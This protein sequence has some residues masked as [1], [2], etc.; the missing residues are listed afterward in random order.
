V[1][2]PKLARVKLKFPADEELV[3]LPATVRWRIISPCDP[4]GLSCP[5]PPL[6]G[7]AKNAFTA[8]VCRIRLLRVWYLGLQSA[9]AIFTAVP[10][11]SARI[12]CFNAAAGKAFKPRECEG[13]SGGKA[14]GASARRRAGVGA[15]VGRVVLAALGALLGDELG[16]LVG[17]VVG[18]RVGALEGA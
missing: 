5:P 18:R 10:F 16:D 15:R 2:L 12:F 8:L 3:Q 14:T 13:A 1:A 7:P 9:K 6:R 17:R 4:V 11:P